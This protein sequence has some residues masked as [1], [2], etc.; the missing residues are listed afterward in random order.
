MPITSKF[1]YPLI[2][3]IFYTKKN[4]YISN[5]SREKERKRKKKKINLL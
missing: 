5:R 1:K 2:I 3:N 4:F